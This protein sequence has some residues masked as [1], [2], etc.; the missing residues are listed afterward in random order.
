MQ[1]FSSNIMVAGLVGCR[2]GSGWGLGGCA[3]RRHTWRVSA[4]GEHLALPHTHAQMQPFSGHAPLGEEAC[5]T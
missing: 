5:L 2:D 1:L 3:N 4:G